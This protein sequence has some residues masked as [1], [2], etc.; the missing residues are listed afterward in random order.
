VISDCR[1]DVYDKPN[2][3]W[4]I[5]HQLIFKAPIGEFATKIFLARVMGKYRGVLVPDFPSRNLSGDLSINSI[6]KGNVHYIGILSHIKKKKVKEDIDCF[7]SLSGPEPQRTILEKMILE[8]ITEI[9]GKIII[10]GGNPDFEHQH[11]EKNVSFYSFLNSKQQEDIMNRAKFIITRSGYTTMME[12]A[13]LEKKHVLLIPTP[14]Q[15]EQEYLG[16]LYNKNNIF[17]HVHQ[18]NLNLKENIKR[19]PEFGGFSVQ[20]KTD[21][22]VRNFM[23]LV[24]ESA[25]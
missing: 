7:I 6:Y 17:Y 4:L 15:T 5:N 24:E 25:Y 21:C 8:Q 1:Y 10:A 20:W 12:L 14:G 2:N 18:H 23:R 11:N 19:A 16:D 22:S 3:S 13:E 9:P